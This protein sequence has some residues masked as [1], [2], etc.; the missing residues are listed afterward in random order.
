M[1]SL[2]SALLAAHPGFIE[3]CLL[4]NELVEDQDRYKQ[5]VYMT[6]LTLL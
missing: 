5:L 6:S 1:P 4:L 2:Q 3:G